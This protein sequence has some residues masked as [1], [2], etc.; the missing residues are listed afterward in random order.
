MKVNVGYFSKENDCTEWE[1]EEE[2]MAQSLARALKALRKYRK[3][4]LKT[5]SERTGI[6]FQTIARYE[7]GENIPSTIQAYKLAY[8]YQFSLNDMF[9]LGL[10]ENLEEE[11][12]E[13][14]D[15]WK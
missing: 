4:S 14:L 2:E 10:T 12:T 15:A 1:I 8:F 3:Y 7:S 13:I 5:V 11:Y 6:P 9:V